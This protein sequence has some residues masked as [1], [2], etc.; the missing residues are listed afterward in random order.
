[1]ATDSNRFP[2]HRA[3]KKIL[4][5]PNSRPELPGLE[6]EPSLTF[7]R[8]WI[9]VFPG[10]W[11]ESVQIFSSKSLESRGTEESNEKPIISPII[12]GS[13][14]VAVFKDKLYC[15][16]EGEG[17][18]GWLYYSAFDG[19]EWSKAELL[20]NDS[21]RISGSP[22][23]AVFKDKLYC[24]HEELGETGWLRYCTFDGNKWSDSIK[25]GNHGTSLRKR[26]YP[27]ASLAVHKEVLYCVHEGYGSK[28]G[29]GWLWYCTFDGKWSKDKKL[30][31]HGTIGTGGLAV[32]E[33]T[34]ICVHEGKD[35]SGVMWY[36]SFDDLFGTNEW[37]E[38]RELV[39]LDA[40]G[41]KV[42]CHTSGP[43]GVVTDANQLYC[44]HE[45]SGN[46]GLIWTFNN[47]SRQD[48]KLTVAGTAP[49]LPVGTSG[50]PALAKYNNEFY[51]LHQGPGNDGQIWVNKVATKK[52]KEVKK[53]VYAVVH[54]GRGDFIIGFKNR[55][56]WFF[57]TNG[58]VVLTPPG[59]L[60]NGGDDYAL[61]GGELGL[62]EDPVTGAWRELFEETNEHFSG[63]RQQPEVYE[64]REPPNSLDPIVKYYGVYL[65]VGN[66]LL[67]FFEVT[68]R[69]LVAGR[70][71]AQAASRGD[72]QGDYNGLRAAFDGCP[73][74]NELNRAYL[75][76]LRRDWPTIQRWQNDRNK[77]WY[78]HIL[79]NLR[80]K[81][82]IGG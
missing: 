79:N 70:A 22:A 27:C 48:E 24:V 61:P 50:P 3:I 30:P 1:M 64:G 6:P 76:G 36:T 39:L 26:R 15:V 7:P 62:L 52:K 9:G 16:F 43:P 41:K 29:K 71:A 5:D 10:E 23:L 19:N 20:G 11:S 66:Q 33:E 59:Q 47:E 58:G 25:L 8:E 2:L 14:A 53:Y 21:N 69:N 60:L 17:N 34:L 75:W 80:N 18:R 32:V 4:D 74:D 45:G 42:K 65:N 37:N 55:I 44:V 46:D 82:G 81:L 31:N 12:S 77:S 68:S 28:D 63:W 72:Y 51:I 54:D 13:P 78:Y 35:G 57:H 56:G 38:D 67:P 40:E 49:Q 73:E